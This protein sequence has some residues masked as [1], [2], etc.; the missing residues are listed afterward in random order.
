MKNAKKID[1][2]LKKKLNENEEKMQALYGIGF[3]RSKSKGALS[4]RNRNRKKQKKNTDDSFSGV[5]NKTY[6]KNN[7]THTPD[8]KKSKISKKLNKEKTGPSNSGS[9]MKK[10]MKFKKDKEEK[11]NNTVVYTNLPGY[12]K[13]YKDRKTFNREQVNQVVDRLYNNEYK[14]RKNPNKENEERKNKTNNYED[15]ADIDEMLERFEDDIKKREE[16]LEIIKRQIRKDEKDIYTYKPK[17]SE[18]SKKYNDVNEEDF[19]ERQKNFYEKKAKKE[20]E[21]R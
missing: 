10:R 8:E 4:S 7:R 17:M 18:G 6:N 12:K 13:F 9:R 21:I 2:Y 1:P 11:K 20:D 19:F 15:E 14:H 5:A 16:N 3:N